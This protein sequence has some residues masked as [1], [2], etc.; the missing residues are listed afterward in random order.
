[1]PQ[2]IILSGTITFHMHINHSAADMFMATH[3]GKFPDYALMEVHQR[4]SSLD[5]TQV[6]MLQGSSLYDPLMLLVISFLG[7][8]LGIDR[9]ILGQTGLGV[10]KLLTLGGCG[11]WYVIDLFLIM[12]ETRQYNYRKVVQ[13]TSMFQRPAPP[14][15]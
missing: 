7:G 13:L 2:M 3:S 1:M 14:M 10:V 6:A 8:V 4:V 11:I 15:Q 12:N 9:F 5:S